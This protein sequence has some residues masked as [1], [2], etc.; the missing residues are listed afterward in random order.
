MS[1]DGRMPGTVPCAA[2][3]F[4]G[5]SRTPGASTDAFAVEENVYAGTAMSRRA[6]YMYGAA[7][8]GRR[9]RWAQVWGRPRRETLLFPPLPSVVHGRKRKPHPADPAGR[10][11]PRPAG[12]VEMPH[13]GHRTLRQAY[14]RGLRLPPPGH[15]GGERVVGLAQAAFDSGDYRGA[16]TLLDHAVFTDAEHGGARS[17]YGD[18]LEQLGYGAENG[19]W[20]NFFLSGATEL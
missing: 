3:A 9:A 14:R 15:L 19:T 2:A 8:V 18:T 6:G 20:R 4:V 16:E 17:R 12:V 13:R 1:T 11:G 7:P 10:A 5:R